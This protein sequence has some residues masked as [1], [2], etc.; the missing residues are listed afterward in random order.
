MNRRICEQSRKTG[1]IYAD[2]GAAVRM[3]FS[4]QASLAALL[5]A[6]RSASS[7]AERLKL[8]VIEPED[9]QQRLDALKD[10]LPEEEYQV[11]SAA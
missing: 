6:L 11:I 7:A 5:A 1:R 9:L 4:N 8:S 2:T 10:S 3:R